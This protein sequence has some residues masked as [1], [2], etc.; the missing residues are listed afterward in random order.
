MKEFKNGKAPG[1]EGLTPIMLKH[2]PENTLERVQWLMIACLATG[3]TPLTWR[4]GQ[5]KFLMK[6]GKKDLTDPR[7]YRPITLACF[8]LKA[9]ERIVS[10]ELEENYFKRR[11]LNRRQHAFQ[12]G[13]SCDTALSETIDYIEKGIERKQYVLGVFLDIKGAFDNVNPDLSLIHI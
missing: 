2:L 10:W 11:P 7:A 1:P 6:P 9:L 3:H 5:L 8:M 13:K 12:L 4:K